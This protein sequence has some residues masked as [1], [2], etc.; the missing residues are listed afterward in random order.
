MRTSPTTP[1]VRQNRLVAAL[2]SDD[3]QRW[4]PYLER[5]NLPLGKVLSE[6]GAITHYV[7]F[8]ITAIV[9]KLHVMENGS[10]AEIAVVGCEGVVG[11]SLVMG[12]ASGATRAMVLCAGSALRMPS[13]FFRTEVGH[14]RILHLMLP[15]IHALIS[16]MSHT[17][18]CNRHHVLDQQLCRWLLLSMDRTQ[19]NCLVMTQ[20]LMATMLGVRR[21]GVTE[22][23][24]KLQKAGLIRYARGLIEIVDRPGLE[25]RA[26]E[27][28]G[29]VRKAYDQLRQADEQHTFNHRHAVAASP[30]SHLVPTSL[31][32]PPLP[33]MMECHTD[34]LGIELAQLAGARAANGRAGLK[35]G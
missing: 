2:R 20:E 9:A 24:M 21:E 16:Q 8:P 26:C 32:A 25:S 10:S 29:A 3:L 34:L 14:L 30:R 28:Y 12:G 13:D 4:L 35:G 11:L 7:Y 18:A 31:R 1:E 5:V 22:A 33:P 15:Y 27:C 17:A 19:G 23:A 6:E